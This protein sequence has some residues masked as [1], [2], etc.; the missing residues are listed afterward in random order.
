MKKLITHSGGFHADDVLAYA[1]LKE[2]L[3]KG[4]EAWTLERSR[5]P[6]VIETGDIVFDVGEI[7]DPA[8]NRYDHHQKD[9][10]GARENGVMYASAG[11]VWKHFGKELC[12]NETVWEGVDRSIIC[13][14]DSVDNGQN[15]IGDLAF[16]DTSY[17][18]LGMHIANFSPTLFE[19]ES[20]EELLRRF[21]E[22]SE[23]ARGIL[24]RMIH[25]SAA[26]EVAFARATEVYVHA[27]DKRLL[28]LDENY[29]RPTWRRLGGYPEPIYVVYP[30]GDGTSWRIEAVPVDA[31]HLESRKLLPESWRGLK[32]EELAAACGASDALFCHPSGFLMGVTSRESAIELAKK[33]LLM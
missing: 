8:T 23:F 28:V 13:E 7:Y 32:N 29:A 25:A 15:F 5:E 16:K 14:I 6:A 30:N 24:K 4:G 27:E 11:L 10:A 18:S 22:A 19:E 26:L 9:R 12:E 31:T 2:A 17:V 21:E 1:I 20:A 33:S 3:T